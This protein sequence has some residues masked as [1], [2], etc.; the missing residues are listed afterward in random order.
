IES[1]LAEFETWLQRAGPRPLR[2]VGY[3]Q[4]E[5]QAYWLSARYEALGHA[6]YMRSEYVDDAAGFAR[7]LEAARIDVVLLPEV[8]DP[9]AHSAAVFAH[10]A[11]LA[12]ANQVVAH[13]VGAYVAYELVPRTPP[14]PR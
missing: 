13:D 8:F 14:A 5:D 7:F 12:R 2:V 11:A 4:R 1:G 6:H 10:M 3:A 9:G